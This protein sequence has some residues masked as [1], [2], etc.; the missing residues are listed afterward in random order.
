MILTGLHLL[1]TYKCT[2]ACDHCFVWGSPWQEGTMS[3]ADVRHILEE[4]RALGTV[5]SIFFEGG[6]PFMYYATLVAAVNMAT[7]MGF[8]SPSLKM[9]S[10]SAMILLLAI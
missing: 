10:M 7:E 2:F 6:E 4:G 3:L 5:E 8:G 1:L 9:E